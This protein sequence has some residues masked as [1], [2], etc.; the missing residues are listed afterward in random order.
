L[1]GATAA[2]K[3]DGYLLIGLAL[4]TIVVYL[5][6]LSN[7]FVL[8]DNR[9]ILNNPVIGNRSFLWK[10]FVN[11]YIW[12]RDGEGL[13]GGLNYRPLHL[14]ALGLSYRLFGLRPVGWHAELILFHVLAVLAAFKIARA[15][16]SDRRVGTLTAAL[17]AAMP[18]QAGGVAF[19]SASQPLSGALMRTRCDFFVI[20]AAEYVPDQCGHV[21]DLVPPFLRL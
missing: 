10:G 19:C 15:V 6:S 11:D 2:S 9:M 21:M 12:F 5:P 18:I 17:F 3:R 8:D 7:T 14:L 1:P 4:L 20:S 13:R 16:S